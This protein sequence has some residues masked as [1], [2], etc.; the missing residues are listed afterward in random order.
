M[1]EARSRVVLGGSSLEKLSDSALEKFLKS[2]Y[3][4]GVREIDSAPAYGDLE[5]RLGRIL[6]DDSHWILNSKIGDKSHLDFP[7]EGIAQQV[8]KSLTLLK[9]NHLGTIFVHS[10][11]LYKFNDVINSSIAKL[12][13]D[14]LTNFLGYSSNSNIED[15]HSA[16]EMPLFDRFQVTCNVLDQSS[17]SAIHKKLETEIYFKRVFGS[18]VLS[19]GFLDDLKL[20]TKILLRLK[21][22]YDTN[23]YHYRFKT[24]FG[25]YH[26]RLNLHQFFFEFV[27]SL[28]R[29]QR[30]IIGTTDS[31]HLKDLVQLEKQGNSL[32]SGQ[33]IHFSDKFK[34][35]E[36]KYGWTPYR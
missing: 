14:G 29:E 4:L 28:G 20:Q 17:L 7:A 1:A 21:D 11:P 3:D 19:T 2:A 6:G 13:L 5:N 15:L 32:K 9:R 26:S 36:S 8:E 25:P 30:V 33:L 35:L 31:K 10:V 18:G 34:E 23:D 22:R 27:L 16:V 12:K 24:I